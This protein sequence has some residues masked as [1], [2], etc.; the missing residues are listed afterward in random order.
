MIGVKRY[1][2]L[3]VF[4]V[5][6]GLAIFFLMLGAPQIDTMDG[7]LTVRNVWLRAMPP[8]G[9]MTAGYLD[10][11]NGTDHA[12]R[13]VGI[14]S[15]AFQDVQIHES[16]VR[17]QVSSMSSVGALVIPSGGHVS[18]RPGGLHLMMMGAHHGISEG[19]RIPLT[20]SF[21]RADPLVIDAPV[22]RDGVG[23]AL[24]ETTASLK[25]GHCALPKVGEGHPK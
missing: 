22:S 20:L 13:I 24:Y 21:D 14:S 10:I 15:S 16:V 5:L 2:L 9:S 3:S 19:D 4:V 18:L 11:A 23:L 25:T 6:G 12:V 1:G 17:E 7:K 8:G